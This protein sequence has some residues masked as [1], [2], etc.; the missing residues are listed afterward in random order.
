MQFIEI[1]G[2]GF[3]FPTILK[4]VSSMNVFFNCGETNKIH[5]TVRYYVQVQRYLVKEKAHW[6]Y[7][8]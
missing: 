4:L 3:F 6:I 1:I 5:V 2:F 7:I 8:M